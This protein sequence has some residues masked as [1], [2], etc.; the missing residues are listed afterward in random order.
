M[1]LTDT[2][3]C[4][5]VCSTCGC[6]AKSKRE[7]SHLVAGVAERL[8]QEAADVLTMVGVDEAQRIQGASFAEGAAGGGAVAWQVR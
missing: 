4:T 7:E 3:R 8:Q 2:G 6:G 5:R 1:S